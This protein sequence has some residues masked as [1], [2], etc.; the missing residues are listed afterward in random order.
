[1]LRLGARVLGMRG[2]SRISSD[3]LNGRGAWI[4]EGYLWDGDVGREWDEVMLL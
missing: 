3:R 4:C 2:S 1:M